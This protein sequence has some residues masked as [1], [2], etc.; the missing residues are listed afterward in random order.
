MVLDRLRAVL[1]LRFSP[2][3]KNEIE[4]EYG[5]EFS[6]ISEI[7][8]DKECV[9]TSQKMIQVLDAVQMVKTSPVPQL[10]LE[11]LLID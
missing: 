2:Q 10:P 3:R 9:I 7:A 6:F 11:L 5:D 4:T 8:G 1:L